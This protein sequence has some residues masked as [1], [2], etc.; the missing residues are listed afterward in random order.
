VGVKT[1]IIYFIRVICGRLSKHQRLSDTLR[2][3]QNSFSL[4]RP[5]IGLQLFCQFE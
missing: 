2:A 5:K 4:S 1:I 3:L